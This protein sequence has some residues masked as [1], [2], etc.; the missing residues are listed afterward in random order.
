MIELMPLLQFLDLV[1]L[2]CDNEACLSAAAFVVMH[3]CCSYVYA[4]CGG[5][6]DTLNK[7]LCVCEERGVTLGCRI[8]GSKP[9]QPCIEPLVTMAEK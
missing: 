3:H 1:G 8:C 6:T 2:D 5:H 7:F 4:L 9:I